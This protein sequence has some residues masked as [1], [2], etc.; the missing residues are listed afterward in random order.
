M[1]A[2][3]MFPPDGDGDLRFYAR[4]IIDPVYRCGSV[5]ILFEANPAK[6]VARSKSKHL[7][8]GDRDVDKPCVSGPFELIGGPTIDASAWHDNNYWSL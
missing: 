7:L 5:Q 3:N 8:P 1:M 6:Q 4:R 2:N